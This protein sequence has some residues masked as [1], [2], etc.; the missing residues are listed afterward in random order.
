MNF[1]AN[2]NQFPG[3]NAPKVPSGTTTGALA[4]QAPLR[5]DISWHVAPAQIV[6]ILDLSGKA[7][8]HGFSPLVSAGP[9]ATAA[10]PGPQEY[11]YL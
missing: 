2:E 9:V 11:K 5:L 3:Q 4:G 8:D 1:V 7:G 10:L 6:A